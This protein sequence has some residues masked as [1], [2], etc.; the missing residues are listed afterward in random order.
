M[1]RVTYVGSFRALDDYGDCFNTEC[2][3]ARA[4]EAN[5]C[6]VTCVEEPRQLPG[7]TDPAF[8]ARQL[9]FLA[10]LIRDH[11]QSTDLL[12]YTR[13]QCVPAEAVDV[14]HAFE[15]AG[16]V[17]ASVH[18]DLFFG[19]HR[20]HEIDCAMFAMQHVFTADGDHQA[21]WEANGV[22]H[23]WLRAG[24]VQ[25]ECVPGNWRGEFACDVA[26]V[27]GGDGYHV[28]W[29]HRQ[30]LLAFLRDR[31]GDRFHKWGGPE[32]RTIRGRDL[33]DLYASARVIVGDT[34]A[35]GRNRSHY[36]S[37]RVYE[38]LGRGGFLIMP[39][40]GALVRE[41]PNLPT[42]DFGDFG[43][44]A[45]HIDYWLDHDTA[46]ESLRAA[47]QE[48]VRDHCTYTHRAAEILETVGLR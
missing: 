41:I 25:D 34:L 7:E 18:L 37:D 16:A 29:P 1:T 12:L 28:E 21:R 24:V 36:W 31:Y 22:N 17:T 10:D 42:F 13:T 27:G 45:M 19:L 23:H 33:N 46:R 3:Y 11:A 35:L 30:E 8:Y 9:D 15:L 32:A 14:W 48:H 44:L 40:I 47:L 4:F 43:E 38:T 39:R 5:G 6:T 26:F 20:E 2:H